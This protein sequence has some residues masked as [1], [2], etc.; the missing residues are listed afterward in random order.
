MIGGL[1]PKSW[2]SGYPIGRWFRYQ[3]NT[4]IHG[5][6]TVSCFT[7]V[8]LRRRG[9]AGLAVPMQNPLF[10]RGFTNGMLW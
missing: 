9:L 1:G 6:Q 8:T 7:L 5:T 2:I 4:T 10:R 3:E